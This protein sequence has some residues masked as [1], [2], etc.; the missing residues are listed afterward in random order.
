MGKLAFVT[1]AAVGYVLGTRAGREAYEQ[2]VTNARNIGQQP[3]VRQAQS[4][5]KDLVGQGSN[6]VKERF[7]PERG[8]TAGSTGLA[9]TAIYDDLAAPDKAFENS[10]TAASSGTAATRTAKKAT[11][12]TATATDPI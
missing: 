11:P 1:G 8:D 2:I 9:D 3:T 4:K 6:A 7:T 10:G 12:A 5:I